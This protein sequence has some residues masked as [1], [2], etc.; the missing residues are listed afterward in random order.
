MWAFLYFVE[1][2]TPRATP[3]AYCYRQCLN[4]LLSKTGHSLH[5]FWNARRKNPSKSMEMSQTACHVWTSVW[6]EIGACQERKF[7]T[8]GKEGKK[9]RLAIISTAVGVER[10]I[11]VPIVILHL[12]W[13]FIFYLIYLKRTTEVCPMKYGAGTDRI[14][15]RIFS[16]SPHQTADY[17]LRKRYLER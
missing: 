12:S 3:Y 7:Y 6:T 15:S 2:L 14:F 5:G 11:Y 16:K 10:E 17:N 9:L 8:E 1:V 13:N 4:S